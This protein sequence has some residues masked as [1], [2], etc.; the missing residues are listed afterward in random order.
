MNKKSINLI[1]ILLFISIIIS[2]AL[3][4]A[5]I[6]FSK[7]IA[8]NDTSVSSVESDPLIPGTLTASATSYEG[9]IP[10]LAK[11]SLSFYCDYE[12]SAINAMDTVNNSVEEAIQVFL[13][14]GV[15]ASDIQ[16]TGISVYYDT[17]Y[18]S[19]NS[20]SSLNINIRDIDNL[21][22]LLDEL[23]RIDNYSSSWY[24]FEASENETAYE[25]AMGRAI[26]EAKQKAQIIA[27]EMG[28]TLG[29]IVLIDDTFDY[30][31]APLR[32][33]DSTAKGGTVMTGTTQIQATVHITF[34][35]TQD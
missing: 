15:S 34:E 23:S 26:A 19:F 6:Y 31:T 1:A 12:S 9:V 21:G 14:N 27:D 7:D 5:A 28:L 35:L 29:K 8:Q 17:Y 2:G 16:S 22:K 18:G 4:A 30:T 11:L 10:D 13:S 24:S 3:I 25:V 33:Y 32:F 20:N